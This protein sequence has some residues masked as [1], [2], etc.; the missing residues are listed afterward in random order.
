MGVL[1]NRG[2]CTKKYV[3]GQGCLC[4]Y[5]ARVRVA[6]L[7]RREGL[8]IP[9]HLKWRV[10]S[11]PTPGTEIKSGSSL[12]LFILVRGVEEVVDCFCIDKNSHTT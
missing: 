12:L 7:V 8:K 2:E 11:T 4:Y 3:E 5:V 1:M 9:C 10:G 6:E